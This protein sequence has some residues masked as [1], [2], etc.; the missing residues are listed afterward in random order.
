[1]S[2][3]LNQIDFAKGDGLV[4]AVVQDA[5]TLQVLMLGY[6][7]A[8]SVSKTLSTQKVTFYSRSRKTLWTKGETSGNVLNLVSLEIDC[9]KDTLLIKAIPNGPTCHEGTLS[10]FGEEGTSGVGFLGHLNNVV[11]DRVGASPDDSYTASLLAGPLRRAAQKVGEE[12]VETALAA[13]AEDNDALLGE[14]ADL[15]YHL[16]VLLRAKGLSLD[17]AV[18]VLRTRHQ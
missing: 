2:D 9:D 3:I 1:M 13:V 16:I 14:S 17:D 18:E 12:G 8:E 11:K 15:L 7:S 6:M 4:P 5:Q 10:C